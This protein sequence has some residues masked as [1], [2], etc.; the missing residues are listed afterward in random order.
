LCKADVICRPVNTDALLHPSLPQSNIMLN[1]WIRT[2]TNFSA[3][4]NNLKQ[5]PHKENRT[6]SNII[7]NYFQNPVLFLFRE[8]YANFLEV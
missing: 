7:I 3:I 5:E 6:P 4:K 1:V 8:K 2:R